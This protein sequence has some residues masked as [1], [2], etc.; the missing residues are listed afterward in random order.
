MDESE[1]L[2]LFQELESDRA[3]RKREY[4]DKLKD[5]I[6]ETIC[7]FAN[8]LPNHNKPGIIFIG[9]NDDGSCHNIT[10]DNLTIEKIAS[11]S[12]EGKILPFPVFTIQAHRLNNCDIIVIGVY[13]TEYTP[14]RYKGEIYI[15]RG[16]TTHKA[17]REEENILVKKSKNTSFDISPIPLATFEDDLDELYLRE[18]YIPSCV[19]R[20]VIKENNRSIE[21]QLSS[22][23]ILTPDG[24]PTV[25]GMLIGGIDTRH[26]FPKSYIQFLRIN[27]QEFG[28]PIIDQEEIDGRLSTML[29]RIYDKLKSHISVKTDITSEYREIMQ[30]D[31]PFEALQQLVANAVMHRTYDYTNT[32][33]RIYWYDN[34]IEIISP[35][36]PFGQVT[37]DNFGTEGITDYRNPNLAGAMKNLGYVQKFGW[38]IPT[39]RKLLAQNNNPQPEFEAKTIGGNYVLVTVRKSQ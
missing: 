16:N 28:D 15:R 7:A 35:G 20:R 12:T 39:A 22:L 33:V 17:N 30:P 34:C 13:P 4:N 36:G 25:L 18:E 6:C 38:G 29:T 19:S 21:S 10:I 32:P 3:D 24:K 37:P 26:F 9:Q 5:S 11:I 8:D 14:I 2:D 23:H 27:G 31:Y 1:L